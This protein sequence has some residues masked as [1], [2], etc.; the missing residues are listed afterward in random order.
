MSIIQY[1][2][3]VSYSTIYSFL[4][5]HVSGSSV[6]AKR[7]RERERGGGREEVDLTI[8]LLIIWLYT[9]STRLMISF[10]LTVT[11][12]ISDLFK[13]FWWDRADVSEDDVWAKGVL[14]DTRVRADSTQHKNCIDTRLDACDD[15]GVHS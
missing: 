3:S 13:V 12:Q 1:N 10:G 5:G 15:V 11:L 4:P 7:A 9:P 14:V 2:E 8:Y 6:C